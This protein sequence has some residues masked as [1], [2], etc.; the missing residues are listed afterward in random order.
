MSVRSV[1]LC[2]VSSSVS[3]LIFSLMVLSVAVC[4][5]V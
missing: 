5:R 1:G 3:L 2:V 4:G